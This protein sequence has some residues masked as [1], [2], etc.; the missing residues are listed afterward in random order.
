MVPAPAVGEAEIQPP[1]R[2]R[3]T[4]RNGINTIITVVIVVVVVVIVVVVVAAVRS[5]QR[6]SL[7]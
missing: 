7:S 2:I 3:G 1:L 5:K 6:L 4:N